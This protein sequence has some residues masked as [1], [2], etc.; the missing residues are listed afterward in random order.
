MGQD[1]LFDTAPA[2]TPAMPEDAAPTLRVGQRFTFRGLL[3]Q[4][5][6]EQPLPGGG[7]V[8]WTVELTSLS[9]WGS[10][11]IHCTPDT[12]DDARGRYTS[13]SLADAFA[14]IRSGAWQPVAD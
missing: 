1:A 9:P 7:S 4:E 14:M 12:E 13:V 2:H 5:G 8:G 3:G 11:S 10:L 6:Y